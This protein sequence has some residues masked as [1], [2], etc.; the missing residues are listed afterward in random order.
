MSFASLYTS[1]NEIPLKQL[2]QTYYIDFSKNRIEIE[3]VN[4]EIKKF[5][6]MKD[7]YRSHRDRY[8]TSLF[9]V[10]GIYNLNYC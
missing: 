3:H 9:I 2:N 8:Q 5:R 10:C 6:I 7:V 1:C 4:R